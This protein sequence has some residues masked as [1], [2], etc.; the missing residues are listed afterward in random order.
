MAIVSWKANNNVTGGRADY[1][2]GMTTNSW[3]EIDITCGTK[4]HALRAGA[5][6]LFVT[7]LF[8]I[9]FER[10]IITF[11]SNVKREFVP[12]DQVSSLLV[13]YC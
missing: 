13:V 5:P 6:L 8:K 3:M 9:I 4:I 12:R 7:W 2:A 11:L 10:L 1:F